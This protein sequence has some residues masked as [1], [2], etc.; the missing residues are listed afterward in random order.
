M[1]SIMSKC[2]D[3]APLDAARRFRNAGEGDRALACYDRALTA[4]PRNPALYFEL[5]GL[6]HA[7][8]QTAVL[9]RS[10]RASVRLIPAFGE[11]HFELANALHSQRRFSE[12]ASSFNLALSQDELG[13]RGM[14]LNNL[15][16]TL[17]ELG[18][19]QGALA[20]YDR[21]LRL[22]PMGAT[23]AF[24]LNGLS[25]VQ[26]ADGRDEEAVSTI[27]RALRVQPDAH[28][29]AFNLG[30]FLRRLKRH[31]EAETN[32]RR[33]RAPGP[34]APAGACPCKPEWPLIGQP[35]MIARPAGAPWRRSRAT[36]DTTRGWALS[37]TRREGR[38]RQCR[39]TRA[40]SRSWH[41]V[42]RAR[43]SWSGT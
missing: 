14:V 25:N 18:D 30:N 9:E 27:R 12:A 40:R 34:R 4:T 17:T 8:G 19:G 2:M 35:P 38:G 36:P 11:G 39:S 28:Y 13:D 24:L 33:A 10:L 23:A 7:L 6:A 32:Y 41:G 20:A 42:G 16:N 22:V 29:A 21:G 5:A 15:A 31:P 1:P 3:A 43:L 26:S 37:C